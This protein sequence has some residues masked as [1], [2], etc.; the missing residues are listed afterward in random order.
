MARRSAVLERRKVNILG[1]NVDD[2]CEVDAVKSV[3]K[4]AE[5]KDR[6]KVVAT[7]NSEF[8]MMAQRDPDFAQILNNAN[9]ALADGQ[10]IVNS[11]LILGG[12]EHD[13]VTGVDLIE[14]VCE[15]S[16]NKAIRV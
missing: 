15:M 14:K 1:V 8:V 13:R 10:W 4:L 7:V 5:G 6:G 12:K 3:L 2:I 16:A 9:L 11:K